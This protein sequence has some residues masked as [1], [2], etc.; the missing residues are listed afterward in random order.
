M[1]FDLSVNTEHRANHKSKYL[2]ARMFTIDLNQNGFTSI[3]RF[4]IKHLK[5]QILDIISLSHPVGKRCNVNAHIS[6]P[7]I[8]SHIRNALLIVRKIYPNFND[9]KMELIL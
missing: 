1:E 2:I 9:N 5:T 7:Q 8:G 3:S 4:L 6:Y